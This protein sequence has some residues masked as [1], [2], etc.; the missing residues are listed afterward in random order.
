MKKLPLIDGWNGLGCRCAMAAG[1]ILL[2]LSHGEMRDVSAAWMTFP[3]SKSS[4]APPP[5]DANHGY[6]GIIRQL[7]SDARTL[8]DQ[9]K[10]ESAV[11]YAERAHRLSLSS[12]SISKQ[13]PELA[14]E[15]IG[16]YVNEL[17]VKK[18]ERDKNEKN[19]KNRA[20]GIVSRT[21]AAPKERKPASPK[22]LV[23]NQTPRIASDQAP[24]IAS[25]EPPR[26]TNVETPRTT[27]VETPRTTR[28]ETPRASSL[29]SPR[30]TT[31]ETPGTASVDTPRVVVAETPRVSNAEAPRITSA[32]NVPSV[33][34]IESA[35]RTA[36]VAELPQS[37][38]MDRDAPVIQP[39]AVSRNVVKNADLRTQPVAA[40]QAPLNLQES[41]PVNL[42][43]TPEKEEEPISDGWVADRSSE[44]RDI[45]QN[46][47][48]EVER[49]QDPFESNTNEKVADQPPV[50]EPRF[51][52]P[53]FEEYPA[54]EFP[55]E[56]V[57]TVAP[58]ESNDDWTTEEAPTDSN[59]R[60][61]QPVDDLDVEESP[62]NNE[63]L[64]ISETEEQLADD[65]KSRRLKLRE[66]FYPDEP[67]LGPV[68]ASTSSLNQEPV[69][70]PTV[71]P[72][73]AGTADNLGDWESTPSNDERLISSSNSNLQ[74]N[75][76]ESSLLPGDLRGK[77]VRPSDQRPEAQFPKDRVAALKKKMEMA[78]SLSPGALAQDA[79]AE[80]FV[81]AS[82]DPALAEKTV[83]TRRIRLRKRQGKLGNQM[84]NLAR[85]VGQGESATPVVAQSTMIQWR[86]F[87]QDDQS[88]LSTTIRF[89]KSDS[90]RTEDLRRD[91][92]TGSIFAQV[93][94]QKGNV[95][96][97]S[98]LTLGPPPITPL[99]ERQM[100]SE[101][102]TKLGSQQNS[103]KR[104][105]V[106]GSLWDN[107]AVPSTAGYSGSV[108][109]SSNMMNSRSVELGYAPKP[110]SEPTV[111]QASFDPPAELFGN[112]LSAPNAEGADLA[113]FPSARE[114]S[115]LQSPT[116]GRSSWLAILPGGWKSNTSSLFAVAGLALFCTG[117]WVARETIRA[118]NS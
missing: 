39:G 58:I 69:K 22:P 71:S 64:L 35:P 19:E 106:V 18:A 98:S 79:M 89:A 20:S 57:P 27:S 45:R 110:P 94:A 76:K 78:V 97:A 112:R 31:T 36:T 113:N 15:L 40:P 6:V 92:R 34:I 83:E 75:R 115:D 55:A 103:G 25:L 10:L 105:Q 4:E 28:G 84:F 109:G 66:R 17:R 93:D 49:D 111:E 67:R 53:Q 9:G 7:I 68:V 46:P 47:L 86:S 43:K 14:P 52:A 44:I 65:V 51:E 99:V 85:H 82:R 5:K 56:E 21:P 118:K 107:A 88:G 61:G 91:L 24:G 90:S 73:S 114:T 23:A 29:E 108:G 32:N 87:R 30:T 8:E 116:A 100:R 38:F 13:A 63:T 101:Q 48:V 26:A 60:S 59:E 50:E 33:A 72:K 81:T 104:S 1:V 42:Q 3:F 80:S 74:S 70:K 96:D 16:K 54:E 12:T 37:D 41:A 77:S 95:P 102:V 2:L 117:V 62:A 11:I